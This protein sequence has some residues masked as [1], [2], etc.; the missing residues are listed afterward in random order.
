MSRL[1]VLSLLMLSLAMLHGDGQWP[2]RIPLSSEMWIVFDLEVNG[3]SLASLDTNLRWVIPNW[4][5]L[6]ALI[7]SG[8]ADEGSICVASSLLRRRDT[9]LIEDRLV[10]AAP[11]GG[12][13]GLAWLLARDR[14]TIECPALGHDE[15]RT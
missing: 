14:T 9:L 12:Y 1:L 6:R 11:P 13:K 7:L 5:A 2:P 15:A 10:G 4:K 3:R 8:D